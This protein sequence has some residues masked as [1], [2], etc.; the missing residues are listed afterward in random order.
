MTLAA[1]KPAIKVNGLKVSSQP[2]NSFQ[3]YLCRTPSVKQ[4]GRGLKVESTNGKFGIEELGLLGG[5][6]RVQGTFEGPAVSARQGH[7]QQE[8]PSKGRQKR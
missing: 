8:R 3:K 6:K 1:G 5:E 4:N 2:L 7:Q